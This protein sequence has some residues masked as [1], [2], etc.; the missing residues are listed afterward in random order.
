MACIQGACNCAV[1]YV[2]RTLDKHDL[3]IADLEDLE[4]TSG[5][6]LDGVGILIDLVGGRSTRGTEDL[7]DDRGLGA[8]DLWG[9][10]LRRLGHQR[11][12]TLGGYGYDDHED[13]QQYQKDVD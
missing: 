10:G 12:E 11:V 3:G 8:I 2:R 1:V 4:E 7:D 13:D 9:V 6:I 5:K